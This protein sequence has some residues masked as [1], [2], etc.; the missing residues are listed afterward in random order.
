[1]DPRRRVR[2]LDPAG[3]GA[4]AGRWSRGGACRGRDL[5]GHPGGRVRHVRRLSPAGPLTRA[6]CA[7]CDEPTTPPS[8]CSSPAPTRRSACSPC[9]PAGSARAGRRLGGRH[10]GCGAQARRLRSRRPRRLGALPR[11]RLDG[12]DGGPRT[13]ATPRRDRLALIVAGGIIYTA[14]SIVLAVGRPNPAPAVFGY[15]EVWH[16]CT[17]LASVCH[18]TAVARRGRRGLNA[19]VRRGAPARPRC[20]RRPRR[21][22]LPVPAYPGEAQRH[23][24]RVTGGGL[25]PSSATSTTSSGPDVHHVTFRPDGQR[26]QAFGLPAQEVVGQTL[27]RLAH[28]HE[29]AVGSAGAEVQVGEPSGAAPVA[30]LG[31]EDDEVQSADRLHLAPRSPTA[32]GL[33]G[34]S[35]DFTITP[36]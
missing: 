19:A 7:G 28:H 5:R 8:T 34:D 17:V 20:D 13:P 6:R 3:A 18:F 22:V 32:P 10:P 23:S 35:R 33:V 1:M 24:A 25:H 29:L 2:A 11:P 4:G 30:P 14:G 36:S 12:S 26:L 31:G 15:H 9:R 21:S 16:S 27:E